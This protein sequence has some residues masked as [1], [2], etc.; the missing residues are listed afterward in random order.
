MTD[1]VEQCRAE[2]KRLGVAD[3]LA[4]EM[5]RDLAADLREAEAEGVSA[6]ELLGSDLYDPASFAATWA[7]ERGVVPEA[8]G[9]RNARRTPIVLLAFTVVAAITLIV[10]ALLLATGE[11]KLSL[12][13]SKARSPHLAPLPPGAVS[14][15]RI[16]H[17]VATASAATPI[18]WIL[19][20]L[21]LLAVCF[22]GWLWSS[23][24]RSRPSIAHA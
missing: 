23:W 11:P 20:I 4:E 22:A 24:A 16:E 2:W 12:V 13:A 7:A 9:R 17:T 15:P 8:P 19:L 21:A 14:P 5:A 3:P 18:E 10:A 1:F 6:E